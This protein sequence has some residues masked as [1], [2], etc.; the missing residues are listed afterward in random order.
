MT[1]ILEVTL[2]MAYRNQT[3][4]NRWNYLA[5]GTA[6]SEGYAWGL[7]DVLGFHSTGGVATSG[8]MLDKIMFLV[9]NT[10]EAVQAICI[11]PYDPEDFDAQPFVPQ[12]P[13]QDGG[14]PSAPFLAVGFRTNQVRRDIRRGTKRF[15]GISEGAIVDGG[16]LS[17]SELTLAIA[18]AN[19]MGEVQ[20]LTEDTAVSTYTPCIV[21]KEKYAV[22][23][24]SPVRYAYRYQTPHDDT[25]KALQLEDVATG[26]VWEP[27]SDVRSQTSRQY[28]RG[29]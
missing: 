16:A 11:N 3:F 2:T 10:C 23:G 28:G 19:E 24:S 25:G 8:T 15:G 7:N 13:G 26:F 5:D 22:P 20:S 18:L 17:S 9:S 4:V 29:I 21:K 1:E 12:I 6:P 14:V 27:Y